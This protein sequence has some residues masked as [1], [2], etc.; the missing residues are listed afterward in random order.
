MILFS[1]IYL[2]QI[3]P[4]FST[5]PDCIENIQFSHVYYQ[6]SSYYISFGVASAH[7]I[8]S[9]DVWCVCLHKTRSQFDPMVIQLGFLT[10]CVVA[11]LCGTFYR[12]LIYYIYLSTNSMCGPFVTTKFTCNNKNA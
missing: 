5:K 1:S 8:W 3:W 6:Y 2:V 4:R 10:Y 11:A 7:R 12:G 9:L